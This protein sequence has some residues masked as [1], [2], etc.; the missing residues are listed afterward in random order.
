MDVLYASMG[1]SLGQISKLVN[2]GV[3]NPAVLTFVSCIWGIMACVYLV[4]VRDCFRPRKDRVEAKSYEQLKAEEAAA[5]P[6]EST[7]P[8]MRLDD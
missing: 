7:K 6:P 1:H 4:W 2:V 3:L 5:A 8:R